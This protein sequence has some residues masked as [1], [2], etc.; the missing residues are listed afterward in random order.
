M[1][2][3]F[4]P[5]GET[6]YVACEGAG[7]V[8]LLRCSDFTIIDS[9]AVATRYLLMLPGNRCLYNMSGG[10]VSIFRRSDNC[11]LRQLQLGT[12][13]GPSVL[14]DGSRLYVPNGNVVTVLGPGPK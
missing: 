13:G 7:R 10:A 14:P 2:A 4:S 3:V 6:A 5:S 8:E 9:I 11:L 1:S 12:T